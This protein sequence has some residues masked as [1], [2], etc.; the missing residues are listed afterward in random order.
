MAT[1][2]KETPIHA[3]DF[4]GSRASGVVEYGIATL[5]GGRIVSAHTRLCAPTGRIAPAESLVHGLSGGELSGRELFRKDY[6]LFASLRKTGPFLAHNASFESSLVRDVWPVCAQATNFLTGRT[7]SDWGP[8]MD[9]LRLYEM[10]FPQ[11]SE[12]SLSTLVAL[13]E[14]QAELDR[15][16][17]VFCPKERRHFHCALYD[18]LGCALLVARLGSLPG[19]EDLTTEW[20]LLES[21]GPDAAQTEL[22]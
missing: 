17:A 5:V 1:S 13:F 8:W 10:I 2:W 18:A 9:S 15:A 12:H 20:L 22:F 3:I 19:Y 11:L 14:L 7:S 21:A 16:A 6:E 4:E